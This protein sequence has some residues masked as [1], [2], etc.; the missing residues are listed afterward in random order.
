MAPVIDA[1]SVDPAYHNNTIVETLAPQDWRVQWQHGDKDGV[2][3][4]CSL[5][6]NWH[7]R[8]MLRAARGNSS[9]Q[10]ALSHS[11]GENLYSELHCDGLM[12]L[13]YVS[14]SPTLYEDE[15]IGWVCKL[16]AWANQVRS[17]AQVSMSEY[18]LEVEF[19]TIGGCSCVLETGFQRTL[20][21]RPGLPRLPLGVQKFPHYPFRHSDDI[22]HS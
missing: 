3:P 21:R 14:S 17:Q 19:M 13:G 4:T 7:W 9:S 22:V 11:H 15:L 18:V 5:S 1:V 10:V 8:P 12:E 6:R 2:L 20:Y 16:P